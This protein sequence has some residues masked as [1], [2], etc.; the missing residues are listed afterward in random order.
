M[1]L[2]VHVLA[3]LAITASFTTSAAALDVQAGSLET[4]IPHPQ[5]VGV[6]DVE[7]SI[8]DRCCQAS[9]HPGAGL[10]SCSTR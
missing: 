4:S 1:R 8:G 6:P 7:F 9:Q 2:L 3:R 5:S 10:A